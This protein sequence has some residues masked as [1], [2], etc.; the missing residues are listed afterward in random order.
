MVA[1]P[2]SAFEFEYFLSSISN[3]SIA[4][5]FILSTNVLLAKYLLFEEQ[6][7]KKLTH[8]FLHCNLDSPKHQKCFQYG[9]T[10]IF[11]LEFLRS[12]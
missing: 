8:F 11:K 3:F 12:Y 5:G 7:L 2:Q 1:E 10:S 9:L 6:W 4:T